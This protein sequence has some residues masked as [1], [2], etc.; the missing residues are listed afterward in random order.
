MTRTSERRFSIASS[1]VSVNLDGGNEK[2]PRSVR[3]TEDFEKLLHLRLDQIANFSEHLRRHFPGVRD[4]PVDAVPGA[5]QRTLV[6]AAHRHGGV[7]VLSVEVVQPLGGVG[8]QVVADFLHRRD[9]SGIDP[10]GWAGTGAEGFDLTAP[11][12]ASERLGHL[13]AVGVLHADEQDA[14]H[15]RTFFRGGTIQ[16]IYYLNRFPII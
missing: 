6:A 1:G 9:R 7:K 13:A 10:T 16:P 15:D 8:G 14:L 4:L 11:V 3:S 12:E 5:H 2:M